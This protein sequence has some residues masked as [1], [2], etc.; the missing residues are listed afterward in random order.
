MGHVKY[1]YILQV[2]INGL[3]KDV[4]TYSDIDDARRS[5]K[6]YIDGSSVEYTVEDTSIVTQMLVDIASE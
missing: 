1:Y 4:N 2:K 3:W 5:R 6:L